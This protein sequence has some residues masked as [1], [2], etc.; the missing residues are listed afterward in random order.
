MNISEAEFDLDHSVVILA[1]KSASG[2]SAVI[3]ALSLCLSN[4]KRASSYADYVM[5]NKPFAKVVL[6]C[7]IW[8]KP[9][10]F[11]LQ[12][13]LKNGT[14][15]QM[16]LH[17]NNQIYKNTEAD[18]IIK[19][20]DLEYYSDLMFS[21]QGDNDITK[22][23][24]SQRAIYLQRL[25]NFDFTEEKE[26][27]KS[28]QN[29]VKE[30][31]NESNNKIKVAN[32]VL[33]VSQSMANIDV[34]EIL[35]KEEIIEIEAEINEYTNKL[36]NAAK[37]DALELDI[38][39]LKREK[40]SLINDLKFIDIDKKACQHGIDNVDEQVKLQKETADIIINKTNEIDTLNVEQ[41]AFAKQKVDLKEKIQVV[42]QNIIDI[43]SDLKIA[44]E[45][46]KLIEAGFC[47]T[48]GQHTSSIG[49]IE[50]LNIEGLR[51]KLSELKEDQNVLNTDNKS[52]IEKYSKNEST[53]R[54]LRND[55]SALEKKTFET[56]KNIFIEKMSELDLKEN[57]INQKIDTIKKSIN[58]KNELWSTIEPC[59]RSEIQSKILALHKK[60]ESSNNAEKL[61]KSIQE[62]EALIEEKKKIIEEEEN[63]LSSLDSDKQTFDEAFNILDKSLPLYMI[64]KVCDNLQNEMN[65]SIQT[66]FPKYFVN[67]DI[68]K[69]GCEFLYT[70]DS[71][72]QAEKFKNNNLLN[73]KMSSGFEKALL[74]MSFKLALLKSYKIDVFIGDEIDGAADEDS[75]LSLFLNLLN[76]SDF[77]QV[78]LISHKKKICQAITSEI[79]DTIVYFANNG[80]FS[81]AIRAD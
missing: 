47:Q 49:T 51:N 3:D 4:K 6:D 57:T 62:K 76:N 19:Q 29:Q 27:I 22:L 33:A 18:D 52:L 35:T 66:I 7:E 28:K 38:S 15:F 41:N 43:Q 45:K 71:S 8:S 74:T 44:L 64:K 72:I 16:S 65:Q 36:S 58:E 75:S 12:I 70:K 25:L 17:Y 9:V 59:N 61:L 14:P 5:Q 48:C 79:S 31:I 55:I 63:N 46:A 1:G 40:E 30:L 77:N 80:E 42:D 2:K 37:R 21:M 68:T 69:K 67:L 81:A 53:I 50:S 39:K 32:E 13:N 26:Y 60:I 23:T 73:A 11:D 20:F 56:D 54:Q 10:K 24:P 34:P 78:F